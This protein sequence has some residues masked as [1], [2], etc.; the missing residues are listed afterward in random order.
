VSVPFLSEIK[1]FAGNFAPRGYAFCNGQLESIAQNT[2]LFSLLGT[3]YG[4]DGQN[5]FALPDLSDRVAIGQGQAPGLSN[6]VLGEALG[7]DS[8]TLT[9][10]NLPSHSHAVAGKAAAANS[11]A[12]GGVWAISDARFGTSAG[13]VNMNP[14]A[15]STVGAASPA[16]HNNL[17]PMRVLNYIIAVEGVF[18]SRN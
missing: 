11:T 13:N 3:A 18:P 16:P 4:G 15:L 8:V 17:Q 2:A 7:A 10:A 12:A 1:L 9:A 6:R 5:T 14:A